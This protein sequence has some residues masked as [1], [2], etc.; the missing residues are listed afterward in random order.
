MVY[1]EFLQMISVQ[2]KLGERMISSALSYL[3]SKMGQDE[4]AQN[5]QPSESTIVMDE[6][7]YQYSVYMRCVLYVCVHVCTLC[8]FNIQSHLGKF[9]YWSWLGLYCKLLSLSIT[10][11]RKKRKRSLE[12]Q[13]TGSRT[14]TKNNQQ[15]INLLSPLS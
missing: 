13:K 14:V 3:S 7:F 8:V 15:E 9:T 4:T 6:N 12:K 11:I 2:K 1:L 5:K 10:N